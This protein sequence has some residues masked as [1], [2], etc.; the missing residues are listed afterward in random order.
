MRRCWQ[1]EPASA[2]IIQHIDDLPRVLEIVIQHR[3][4]VAHEECLRHGHRLS[5]I[6]GG[7]VLKRKVI[8]R[9]RKALLQMGPVNPDAQP[10]LDLLLGRR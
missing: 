1:L 3:G 4:A 6:N 7:R 10:A 8:S 2:R 9:Q 5:A